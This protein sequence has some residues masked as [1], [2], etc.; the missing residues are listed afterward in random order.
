MSAVPLKIFVLSS[1]DSNYVQSLAP[2]SLLFSRRLCI[3]HLPT[4][5]SKSLW[6]DVGD[7]VILSS[8]FESKPSA[9][10]ARDS[11]VVSTGFCACPRLHTT[12][13]RA[14]IAPLINRIQREY[15]PSPV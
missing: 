10:I 3:F 7:A 13:S 9:G 11:S 15:Q 2:S 12:R 6:D 5:K 1:W 8:P 4:R 14:G